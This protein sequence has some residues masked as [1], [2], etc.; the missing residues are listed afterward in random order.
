MDKQKDNFTNWTHTSY[1]KIPENPNNWKLAESDFR[2]FKKTAWVVTEKIHGAN[3]CI[4]TDG[5]EV[6]F[7]KKKEFLQPDE[8]FFGHQSLQIKLIQ[9]VKEIFKIIQAERQATFRVSVYG[10]LFGGEY[11]HSDVPVN[12]NVQAVQTGIYYSPE[13]EFCAFD[14]AVEE[15]HRTAKRDYIDYEKTLKLFQQVEMLAAKPLFIGKY[16]QAIA[17]NI[18]FESTIP[19]LLGLPKLPFSNQAEGI[20]IKPVKSIYIDTPKGR[21]RPV[22]KRKIPKFAEESRFHQAEKWSSQ[23]LATSPPYLSDEKWLHEAMLALVTENR[24]MNTLSKLGRVSGKDPKAIDK[25]F[26][27]FV[28]DV[29]ETF[30]ESYESIFKSLPEKSQQTLIEQLE[31]ESKKLINNYFKK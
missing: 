16:E 6:R 4:V 3:F 11:P 2:A 31:Q 22:L 17:Q 23:K 13:I 15:N 20:V 30:D 29:I 18:E 24:L 26:Q 7:A 1:E 10:E 25:V 21:I 9:Q 12:P 19:G 5:S 14:I 27:L 8:D 28:N